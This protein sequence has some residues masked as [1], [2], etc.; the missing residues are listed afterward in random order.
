M[1]ELQN[2]VLSMLIRRD[3][4]YLS[5][6]AMAES[7][8]VTRAGVLKAIRAL[9][10]EG[11]MVQSVRRI[12][13]RLVGPPPVLNAEYIE[14]R[15]QAV[16][17]DLW[18]R[19]FDTIDSTNNEGKRGAHHLIRPQL[20]A[21]DTQTAG[22]GRRCH[23][24]YSPPG[25]GLYMSVVVPT[26]LPMS[27]AALSTQVMA[28]AASRAIESLDGPPIRIKWVN[29]LY[30][31]KKKVAGILTEAVTDL[32][33]QRTEAIVCGIGLN[34]TTE[35]FPE[36]LIGGK[37]FMMS[38]ATVNHVLISNNIYRIFGNYLHGK[39]C[40]PIG[41]GVLVFLTEEDRFVP[42]FMVVCDRSKV[43]PNGVHGTPDLVVEVLSPSTARYDR[44]RKKDVYEQCGVKEYWIVSA[45]DK[46]V[47][48]YIL[49]NG[50][51]RLH[52]VYSVYPDWMLAK[53]KPEERAEVVTEFRCSLYDDLT[54]SL[55]D[56]FYRIK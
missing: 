42:D 3:G 51:Y 29:D 27:D 21:A 26:S 47:E 45:T 7:L 39:T 54:I 12:G 30:H 24:F 55:D 46:S 50:R 20:I 40:L 25:S 34:L 37:V 18:V 19:V 9:Q 1:N 43:R 35:A 32:E 10:A 38:P 2:R 23:S 28:V 11:Y 52:Q 44:G 49:E 4:A 53:M 22:R 15:L 13:H 48:Q 17:L 8:H 36:E 14:T 16:G 56:I 41:D 31:G 33:T 5:G 6:E